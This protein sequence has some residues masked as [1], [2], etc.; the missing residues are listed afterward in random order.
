MQFTSIKTSLIEF[1][2]ILGI[3]G[4]GLWGLLVRLKR[5]VVNREG[6]GLCAPD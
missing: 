1:D 2:L 4:I 3:L 5:R 6:L